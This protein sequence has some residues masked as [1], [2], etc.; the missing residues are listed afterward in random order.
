MAT[1]LQAVRGMHDILPA[2]GRYFTHLETIAREILTGY[3]Y[4]EIR[5]PLVES[6]ELFKRTIGEVT[7][8]VEKEM[9]TFEDRN[10]D[11]LSRRQ[12]GN[13]LRILDSKNPAMAELI[14]GAPRLLD[15]L[16]EESRAHFEGLCRLLDEAG[17]DYRVNPRLVRGLDYYT[18]TVF[19]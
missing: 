18:K 17:V 9:Y 10:G 7:D 2:E 3:G 12:E 14:A 13:P 5:L 1:T 8:I 16:D 11:S 6:T 19:E 15:A 4:E